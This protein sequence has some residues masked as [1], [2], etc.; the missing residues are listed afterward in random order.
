VKAVFISSLVALAASASFARSAQ[1]QSSCTPHWAPGFGPSGVGADV[2][3]LAVY[4]EGSGPV[5]FAGGIFSCAGGAAV[6][7]IAR[8]DGSRWSRIGNDYQLGGEYLN[9]DA[10]AFLVHD[11]GS[12]SAL[13]AGFDGSFGPATQPNPMNGVVR[14]DGSTW[15]AVGA[16]LIPTEIVRVYSLATFDDRSGARP[17]L[18]A[19]GYFT[20]YNSYYSGHSLARWD[21]QAWHLVPGLREGSHVRAL[22]SFDDDGA[23]AH[24]PSLFV[25]GEYVALEGDPVYRS[26][27]RWDGA[28]WSETG[29][30]AG[31]AYAM[32]VYDDGSGLGPMLYAGGNLFLG[33]AGT[34]ASVARWDGTN[35][36]VVSG[37][38]VVYTMTVL[39]EGYGSEL[40]VGGTTYPSSSGLVAGVS[41]WNG[42]S[43]TQVANISTWA[44]ASVPAQPSGPARVFV[45]GSFSNVGGLVAEN[46]VQ[47]SHGIW[48]SLGR[49]DGVSGAYDMATLHDSSGPA[50]IVAGPE[51]AGGEITHGIAKWDGSRWSSLAGGFEGH[52]GAVFSA[53]LASRM[54]AGAAVLYAAGAFGAAGGVPAKNIA[55][56]NGSSWSPL[57]AGLTNS[58][59]SAAGASTLAFFDDGN[60][61]SLYV[62]GAFDRAGDAP[63]SNIAKWD[64]S[65]WSALG[66]GLN[67]QAVTL[68][69]FDDGSGPALY[70]TGWFSSAGGIP[71]RIARWNGTSWADVQSGST[72]YVAHLLACDDGTGP[73]LF[74]CGEF[75]TLSS[76]PL[77]ALAKWNGS[78]WTG[79]GLGP[80][81]RVGAIAEFDDGQG[82][83]L[84][85]VGQF[86]FAD[87]SSLLGVATW[88][89]A[90]WRKVSDL[91]SLWPYGVFN[92][93][94]FDDGTSE[95]QS[96]YLTGWTGSA[97]A[98]VNTDSPTMANIAE[99]KGCPSSG[100]A[101]CLGDGS[102]TACPCNNRSTTANASGCTNSTGHAGRLEAS[103]SARIA[104]D[105]FTL[106]ASGM[107]PSM[108]MFV[109]GRIK[110]SGGA[111]VVF[112]DGLR[113][114]GGTLLR[115]GM[116]T[117]G[118]TG[119][120]RYPETGDS[121][122]A[123]IGQV[124]QPGLRTYQVWY[125]DGANFCTSSALNASNG[126]IVSWRP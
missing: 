113:C 80:D 7:G 72:G 57:G 109:Q 15:S 18:Y 8:W 93:H 66:L 45:G 16:G 31:Q 121:P 62:A 91:M 43:W 75:Q 82:P 44:L 79:F 36:S 107:P 12:G 30:I 35:W 70:A 4:D 60:G 124:T 28:N 86:Y 123:G 96:L 23:G 49:G 48:S 24:P 39:D 98:R 51:T 9:T 89:G 2:H 111:G 59:S 46:V 5:L 102:G 52:H 63:V 42:T 32:C 65:H 112:G 77:F 99:W 81:S 125:R 88:D 61:E 106:E 6:H 55:R 103:G 101:Y 87:G 122:I 53:A 25:G 3:A 27:L 41:K 14:W 115:L 29:V 19:G 84:W 97:G 40:W 105:T 11:D 117:I 56:W 69:S 10:D 50:L 95:G 67:G 92:L 104:H 126:W 64:G 83:E 94:A 54:E 21:G 114:V 119:Y 47:R 78:A 120:A 13:Y 20:D 33:Q 110:E 73:A 108:C 85:A 37:P 58:N 22:V 118:S 17:Q 74:A 68:C 34:H 90:R 38:G 71:A 100:G 116:K 76:S 1:A 26:I